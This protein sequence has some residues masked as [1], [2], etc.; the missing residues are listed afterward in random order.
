MKHIDREVASVHHVDSE[1]S[2]VYHRQRRC[3][4]FPIDC[5]VILCTF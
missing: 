2:F 4:V 5:G 1:V 3:F